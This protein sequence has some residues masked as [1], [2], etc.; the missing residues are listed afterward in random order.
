MAWRGVSLQIR[1]WR[2]IMVRIF[3][4]VLIGLVSLFSGNGA[5]AEALSGG[6]VVSP[7]EGN[8]FTAGSFGGPT[9]AA[10][11]RVEVSPVD[12]EETPLSGQEP[13]GEAGQDVYEVDL[14]KVWNVSPDYFRKVFDGSGDTEPSGLKAKIEENLYGTIQTNW[15]PANLLFGSLSRFFAASPV[16]LDREYN[17]RRTMLYE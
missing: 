6:G 10:T 16:M 4:L 3:I 13:G 11:A 12:Q 17:V 14:G 1:A 2:T 15:G 8:P 5:A 7:A 9:R